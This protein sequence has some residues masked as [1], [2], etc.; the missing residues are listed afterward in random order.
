MQVLHPQ[1]IP[2]PHEFLINRRVNELNYT[3]VLHKGLAPFFGGQWWN[4]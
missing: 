3:Q 4:T 1:E 2:L